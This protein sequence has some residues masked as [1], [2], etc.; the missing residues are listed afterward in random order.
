MSA[1]GALVEMAWRVFRE[2]RSVNERI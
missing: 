2:M 1:S